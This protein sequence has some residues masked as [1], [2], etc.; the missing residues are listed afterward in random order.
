MDG[1][2]ILTVYQLTRHIKS[3]L[4]SDAALRQVWVRGEISNFTHHTSGHMYFTLKDPRAQIRCVMFRSDNRFLRFRPESG[5]QVIAAGEI[6]VYEP[7]GTYQLYVKS[8]Q[9]DGIGALHLGFEQLKQKLAAEGL[10]A[11]ERKRPLPLLPTRIGIVTSLSGAAIR[12]I[13][14]ISRR[15]FPNLTLV[16]APVLVQGDEAPPQIARAISLLNAVGNVEVI[17]VGRGGG[18]MEDLWA[19]NDERVARAIFASRIPV[20]SAV[21]HET[22]FTISDFVADLRAP[23]PSA[24]AEIVVPNRIELATNIDTAKVRLMRGLYNRLRFHREYLDRLRNSPAFKRPFDHVRRERQRLDE[25]SRRLQ[26]E[27][28]RVLQLRRQR[29]QELAGKLNSLSP[30]SVL[31][32]GYSLAFAHPGQ[33]LLR[34]VQEIAAGDRVDIRLWDGR[35]HCQVLSTEAMVP[36][37][38]RPD[39]DSE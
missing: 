18:S 30:M 34:S 37:N 25:H 5:M 2:N 28:V 1:S 26:L 7:A 14:R 23:T 39:A 4:E 33:R 22:D 15:R 20:V 27:V 29:L 12:D 38:S 32:R 8:L 13:I 24:A 16:I 21:G 10:F 36:V 19:F 31:Q 9:P 35:I 3:R 17:I 6:G 11:E